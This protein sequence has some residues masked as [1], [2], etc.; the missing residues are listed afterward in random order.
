[1]VFA[2][3]TARTQE[4][5]VRVGLLRDISTGHVM[6][7]GDHGPLSV[8]ADGKQ[9]AI[10]GSD[11][12]LV[13]RATADGIRGLS[14]LLNVWAKESIILRS[15]K[16]TGFRMRST[17]PRTS[18]RPYPGSIELRRDGARFKLIA[19]VPLEEYVA[20][21]VQAEAGRGHGLEYYKLQAV[22]CRTWVLA[23]K[24][25]HLAEGFEVCDRTH[26]QVFQ[27]RARLDSINQA[28]FLT[29]DMVVVD[30]DI[31]L[32]HATFHSNC[33]GETMNAEDLWSQ[34][35][36][37]LVSVIDTFCF[38]APHARWTERIPR[39]TW[40][41][42]LKR[43]FGV[44]THDPAIVAQVTE[45]H[46]QCREVY[47]S[48]ISPLVSLEQVRTDMHFRSAYFSMHSDGND[49]IF[50]GKGFGHGIG[51][52]QEGAMQMALDGYSYADILHHYFTD[53]HIVDLDNLEFFRDDGF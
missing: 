16:G 20:G 26:C 11:D 44:D 29:R 1:M 14:L 41:A 13:L 31:Q 2:A 47:L 39:A 27:G 38:H 45:H 34:H 23:N 52:C 18:E 12:G 32:I 22:S 19:T 37:Y 33:G 40:L 4:R 3:L 9:V 51:L 7:M 36:P 42:Y 21:V 25:K 53:V 15:P 17:S 30:S 8:W 43:Q 48:N 50:D 5:E 46:P 24:R 49:V 35:E 28:V 6:V 10:L